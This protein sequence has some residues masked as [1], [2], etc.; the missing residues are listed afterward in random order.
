MSAFFV[1]Q[2][3]SF[4]I[5]LFQLDKRCDFGLVH[6]VL[7]LESRLSVP[8]WIRR[9]NDS[10]FA[11]CK[12]AELRTQLG[13]YNDN[14]VDLNNFR[15]FMKHHC[16]FTSNTDENSALAEARQHFAASRTC[17]SDKEKVFSSNITAAKLYCYPIYG[18]S[19]KEN[20]VLLSQNLT[21]CIGLC[22]A[23][24]LGILDQPLDPLYE[25]DLR[26]SLNVLRRIKS[27]LYIT[28]V[29]YEKD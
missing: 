17:Y 4:A 21:D 26:F 20:I 15:S 24:Q 27:E 11:M 8:L 29:N 5:L 2:Y 16:V 12:R 10:D 18:V 6:A 23:N 13:V 25:I 9:G 19:P 7:E 3:F 28:C 22:I 14:G 1:A